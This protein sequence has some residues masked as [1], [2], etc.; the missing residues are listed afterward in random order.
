MICETPFWKEY[1]ADV[2]ALSRFLKSC[3]RSSVRFLGLA[4][5]YHRLVEIAQTEG[6]AL[7][8]P[9]A[10]WT[11]IFDGA[12]FENKHIILLDDIVIRGTMVDSVKQ[13]FQKHHSTIG[14]DIVSLA[15]DRERH[16]SRVH[17]RFYARDL[18][19]PGTHRFCTEIVNAIQALGKPYDIDHPQ[20]SFGLAPAQVDMFL[21]SLKS[22][23]S[24]YNI[25]PAFAYR[26]GVSMWTV[27]PSDAFRSRFMSR[28]STGTVHPSIAKW[29]LFYSRERERMC[30][31]SIIVSSCGIKDLSTAWAFKDWAPQFQDVITAVRNI[32]SCNKPLAEFRVGTFFLRMALGLELAC[33][34][35]SVNGMIPSFDWRDV[36]R[37]FGPTMGPMV[38]TASKQVEKNFE[39]CTS[40]VKVPRPYNKTDVRTRWDRPELKDLS[41]KVLSVASPAFARRPTFTGK[42]ASIFEALQRILEGE[43]ERQLKNV[44]RPANLATRLLKGFNPDELKGL[45]YSARGDREVRDDLVSLGIDLCDT[46]GVLSPKTAVRFGDEV[47]RYF[48]YGED[49]PHTC[50]PILRDNLATALQVELPRLLGVSVPTSISFD[51]IEFEKALAFALDGLMT[52]GAIEAGA[53]LSRALYCD[54]NCRHPRG[55]LLFEATI[56]GHYVALDSDFMD[57]IAGPNHDGARSLSGWLVKEHI[58]VPGGGGTRW[59]VGALDARPTNVHDP[60]VP[61]ELAE[62]IH[63]ARYIANEVVI[64]C[65]R[66]RHRHP[67]L[68]ALV[69]CRDERRFLYALRG[70]LKEFVRYL[71]DSRFP[72]T[73]ASLQFFEKLSKV[74]RDL[75]SKRTLLSELLKERATR[76]TNE[77][78]EELLNKA[79][80]FERRAQIAHEVEAHFTGVPQYRSVYVRYLLPVLK[81]MESSGNLDNE[82]RFFFDRMLWFASAVG[83]LWQIFSNYLLIFR[84]YWLFPSTQSAD[85]LEGIRKASARLSA[86]VDKLEGLKQNPV[87]FGGRSAEELLSRFQNPLSQLLL[88]T[89]PEPAQFC[90]N[91]EMFT[92]IFTDFVEIYQREYQD[93]ET[94]L[95]HLNTFFPSSVVSSR[96][97]IR[98]DERG[99][100]PKTGEEVQRIR[101]SMRDILSEFRQAVR[102]DG[103]VIEIRSG[104]MIVAL[105]RNAKGALEYLRAVR[106]LAA[107]QKFLRTVLVHDCD[108]SGSPIPASDEEYHLA[109]VLYAAIDG[110]VREMYRGHLGSILAVSEGALGELGGK[111]DLQRELGCVLAENWVQLK[112]GKKRAFW[113]AILIP[114]AS[115]ALNLTPGLGHTSAQG[116]LGL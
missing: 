82:A 48:T 57:V 111:E 74:A 103:Y 50:I 76:K 71:N 4:R 33:H 81:K 73:S 11:C 2:N 101:L 43:A 88:G 65:L 40:R 55:K 27:L 60:K 49:A 3:D 30:V 86:A 109:D 87:F 83:T 78:A 46:Y 102:D 104:D 37:A 100:T 1:G 97:R 10:D 32:D 67:L 54:G 19:L 38:E 59:N 66:G 8:D 5:K 7:P 51:K 113:S 17:L 84:M 91:C 34:V 9:P 22:I 99:S 52:T 47:A 25:T 24:I 68:V 114:I 20:F 108:A 21:K 42:L 69:S 80:L 90:A 6:V 92:A 93:K 94:F 35:R 23:G 44:D 95:N 29:R 28:Y 13:H 62:R 79:R 16:D 58:I 115:P 89:R 85:H 75:N 41:D 72:R 106:G 45:I 36:Q 64:P 53:P 31:C 105:G 26:H 98:S 39:S 18:G 14:F 63:V 70:D 15:R 112:S 12:A 56:H 107:Q 61:L 116:K 77:S 110:K 96:F